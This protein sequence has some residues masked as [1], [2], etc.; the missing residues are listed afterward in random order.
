MDIVRLGGVA[1]LVFVL[2]A[3]SWFADPEKL[4]AQAQQ[5]YADA[6]YR[7]AR[8]RLQALLEQAPRRADAHYLLAK[9]YLA[10]GKP[11]SALEAVTTA[12][13]LGFSP[14]TARMT[15]A[16][17]LLAVGQPDAVVEFL[18][19]AAELERTDQGEAL[20]LLG[21]A[22]ARLQLWESATSSYSAA[23]G[24]EQ[25]A[26]EAW[27]ALGRMHL[28]RND[29]EGAQ[30]YLRKAAGKAPEDRRVQLLAGDLALAE[31]HPKMARQ[32]FSS[33][34]TTEYEERAATGLIQAMLAEGDIEAASTEVDRLAERFPQTVQ[35]SFFRAVIAKAAGDYESAIKHASQ[36]Y[37]SQPDFVPGLLIMGEAHLEQGYTSVAGQYLEQAYQ[38]DPDNLHV[39][40]QLARVRER[41]GE[42]EGIIELLEPLPVDAE[43]IAPRLLLALAY[44]KAGETDAAAA[45]AAELESFTPEHAGAT[46]VVA[47][48]ALERADFKKAQELLEAAL[49]ENPGSD[50]LVFL[51]GKAL[52]AREDTDAAILAW[53]RLLLD[54]PDHLQARRGLVSAY[55]QEGRHTDVEEHL[56]V[57]LRE[58]SEDVGLRVLL[59]DVLR[60]QGKLDS[61]L[62]V[63]DEAYAKNPT[64]EIAVKRYQVQQAAGDESASRTLE[65]HLQ[66][67][68][69]DDR[70]RT[71]LAQVYQAA[72]WVERSIDEYEQVRARHP[73]QPLVLNNL[74]WLYHQSGDQRAQ[75][76]AE[77][78]LKLA[79]DSPEVADTLGRIWMAA[80]H[81]E[82]ALPLLE[83]AWSAR[84]ENP[85]I[86]YSASLAYIE[87]GKPEKARVILGELL[88]SGKPFPS[89][90]EAEALRAGL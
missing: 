35:S 12:V 2:S 1:S 57:L 41:V 25:L 10:T 42:V 52:F 66:Q 19:T 62:A 82:R 22:Q 11:G 79:P 54:T 81:I 20:L 90:K 68:P 77:K 47:E 5:A 76:L 78:A 48:L 85:E 29:L 37:Q 63:Y 70:V 8:V 84:P 21:H 71:L 36:V 18:P 87:A 24:F 3:C 80:G 7:E 74:A 83:K 38:I 75:A 86:G 27:L 58:R 65:R 73:D 31:D 40:L 61:A 34:L 16:R 13:G 64:G 56:R 55:L 45:V 43:A 51:L 33:I 6:N 67:H 28:S 9:S 17:A 46:A 15:R 4:F 88:S 69:K 39:R 53:E 14:E 50:R 30:D 23:A 72:G 26:V 60:Q 59:G 32:A 44:R 49:E 89:R